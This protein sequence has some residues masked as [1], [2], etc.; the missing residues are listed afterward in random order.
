MSK[1]NSKKKELIL[2]IG[3]SQELYDRA[4]KKI[5]MSDAMIASYPSA[6]ALKQACDGMHPKSNPD[7][8]IKEGKRSE[9]V[10]FDE[11]RPDK[12]TLESVMETKFAMQNR[13]HFDEGNLQALL[14]NI[15]RQYGE[16]KPVR[17]IKDMN[18]VPK[19]RELVTKFEIYFK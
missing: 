5:G 7:A 13:L 16:Q 19:K 6:E 11:N 9:P 17:I 12:F 18:L 8:R 4:R 3:V 2:G 1:K 14:R 15:N 10:K